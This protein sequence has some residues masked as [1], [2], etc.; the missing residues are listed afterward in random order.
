MYERDA[1]RTDI[2]STKF[3]KF[4]EPA[5]FSFSANRCMEWLRVVTLLVDMLLST[6]AFS[7]PLMSV[8]YRS[9][10]CG[11]TKLKHVSAATL[12]SITW[13]PKPDWRWP[14]LKNSVKPYPP[15]E[16]RSLWTGGSVPL[17]DPT[18]MNEICSANKVAWTPGS[19]PLLSNDGASRAAPATVHQDW[20]RSARRV[21]NQPSS[22]G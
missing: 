1:R 7:T 15:C 3:M 9:F 13:R 11:P 18:V 21:G 2:F 8:K 12:Q 5:S 6:R 17:L 4:L 16:G 14:K 10:A 20:T 19:W 22:K